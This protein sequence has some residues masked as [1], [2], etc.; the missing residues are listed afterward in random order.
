MFVG[1]VFSKVDVGDV[2]R[3]CREDV[4]EG[5]VAVGESD[6]V[7]GLNRDGFRDELKVYLIDDDGRRFGRKLCWPRFHWLKGNERFGKCA[8]YDIGNTQY[9]WQP[10]VRFDRLDSGW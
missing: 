1:F 10:R 6:L 2:A 9:H 7:S 5:V 8:G 3:P 4:V